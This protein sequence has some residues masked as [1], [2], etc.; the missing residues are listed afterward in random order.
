L[1]IPAEKIPAER[2]SI[3]CFYAFMHFWLERYFLGIFLEEEGK[4]GEVFLGDFP[5]GRREGWPP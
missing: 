4:V 1:K 5:R 2:P 3:T